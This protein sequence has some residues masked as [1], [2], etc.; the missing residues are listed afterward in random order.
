MQTVGNYKQI[1]CRIRQVEEII[2]EIDL[3]YVADD[4]VE[5][6]EDYQI[7]VSGW[8]IFI[9]ELHIN[10]HEGVFCNYDENEKE[11]LP[12]F[13]ITIIME[14]DTE[15]RE[16]KWI[17]YEQDGFEITLANYFSG[18]MAMET[19]SELPCFICIPNDEDELNENAVA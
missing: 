5:T 9:P 10:V 18:K 16:G 15:R 11:Y 19:I 2:S 14:S 1:F 6:E 13:S 17:Y 8:W 7:V 3:S 12:D 4:V